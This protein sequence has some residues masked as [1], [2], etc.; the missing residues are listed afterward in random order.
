[1]GAF[2]RLFCRIEVLA[3]AGIETAFMLE[4]H[5]DNGH[6]DP[7]TW[8]LV[9]QFSAVLLDVRNTVVIG[10]TVS[11]Y[12]TRRCR[13]LQES[14]PEEHH[15]ALASDSLE[16]QRFAVDVSFECADG[17]TA[18]E[19]IAA[20]VNAVGEAL[21]TAAEEITEFFTEDVVEI[22]DDVGKAV[23]GWGEDS[24]R[25]RQRADSAR[26]RQAR[27]VRCGESST[28]PLHQLSFLDEWRPLS[29]Q[30]WSRVAKSGRTNR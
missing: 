15:R 24:I 11:K 17:A 23:E 7:T 25:R 12:D 2:I 8:A 16:N 13:H 20:F 4:N 6:A 26:L 19:A 22:G 28:R 10:A 14:S 9:G 21:E 18:C 3:F 29:A 27:S 30:L 1:L 5:A